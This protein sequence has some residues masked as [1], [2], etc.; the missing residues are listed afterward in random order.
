[1]ANVASQTVLTNKPLRL[2]GMKSTDVEGMPLYYELGSFTVADNATTGELATS[3]TNVK[4]VIISATNS[5][6]VTGAAW[7]D[8]VITDG[9]ITITTT[10]P[11]GTA[12]YDYMLIGTVETQ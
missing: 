3:L 12:V 2:M 10:D 11:G 5:Y 4:L 7:S 6:A 9:A 1:M 8:K